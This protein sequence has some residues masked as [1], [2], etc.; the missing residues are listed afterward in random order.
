M[1]FLLAEM[2]FSLCNWIKKCVDDKWQRILFRYKNGK[3][4]DQARQEWVDTNRMLD[5]YA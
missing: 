2:Y 1:F 5:N 3:D 4:F